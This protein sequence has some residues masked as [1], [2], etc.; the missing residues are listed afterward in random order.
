MKNVIK[1]CLNK[2]AQ[3][4]RSL[5][6]TVD[7]EYVKIV[8]L[9]AHC[10][11]KLVITG[12]GK[13]LL[14]GKKIA[15][16]FVSLGI[17]AIALSPL[18]MM[19]GDIGLLDKKDILVCFSKSGE[20]KI[21]CNI[22][23]WV[24]MH[25]KIP[26]VSILGTALSTIY[27][28]SNNCPDM[29]FI[30]YVN[31]NQLHFNV[32][33]N[34]DAG[35]NS[36]FIAKTE[37]TGGT[38]STKPSSKKTYCNR[39]KPVRSNVNDMTFTTTETGNIKQYTITIGSQ[40]LTAAYNGMVT[41]DNGYSFRI[42]P[43]DYDVFWSD[44]C[45]DSPLYLNAANGYNN[46]TV[47]TTKPEDVNNGSYGAAEAGDDYGFEYL[48]QRENNATSANWNKEIECSDIFKTNEVGSVGWMLN[49][50]LNYIKVIGPILVV[51]LSAIDFIKAIFGFDEK[52]MTNAYHKLIIRLIAAIALFLVPTLI[53]VLLSFINATT[54]TL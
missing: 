31:T 39:T 28:E 34:R 36:S 29:Q 1:E 48:G 18:S 9:F 4:L 38:S 21:L 6:D 51:L 47:Q 25:I 44:K 12:V 54:C 40:T 52:A 3:A 13:S 2:E 24:K 10:E 41:F 45:N 43:D 49:T 16:S 42:N 46:M 19:H 32:D 35:N 15:A 37:S 33:G 50:V 22:I 7:D 17:K 14:V 20:T 26:V 53:Q 27:K 11:G 30:Y 5:I 8:T 23:E